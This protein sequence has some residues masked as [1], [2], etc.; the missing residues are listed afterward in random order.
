MSDKLCQIIMSY[1]TS[2]NYV[3]AIIQCYN[4]I[5]INYVN[6][7]VNANIFLVLFRC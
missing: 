4:A 6:V 2:Y 7:I 3:N 5:S 1:K